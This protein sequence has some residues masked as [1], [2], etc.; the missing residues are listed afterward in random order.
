MDD[1]T[2]NLV[3]AT[4]KLGSVT[5]QNVQLHQAL[6]QAKELIQSQD[7]K[8]KE[9]VSSSTSENFLEAVQSLEHTLKQREAEIQR[10]VTEIKDTRM[11]AK[12]EQ[13]L[14]MSAWYEL[15][16]QFQRKSGGGPV[17]WLGQQRQNLSKSRLL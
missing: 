8:I 12:R 4:Q 13:R 14:M 9:L 7:K 6:K 1:T 3:T 15:G 10:L 11:A 16:I 2:K 5:E 17:S